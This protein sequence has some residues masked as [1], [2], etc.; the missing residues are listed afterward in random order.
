MQPGGAV[1]ERG[2]GVGRWREKEEREH[3][4]ER[5]RE[6][7]FFFL[8]SF[9]PSQKGSSSN[10]VKKRT[11]KGSSFYIHNKKE[12]QVRVCAS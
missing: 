5:E 3:L 7:C 9:P 4:K 6:T 8:L 12:V 10:K 11:R 1:L 2:E